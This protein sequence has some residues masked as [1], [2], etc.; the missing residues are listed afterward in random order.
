M[1]EV[2]SGRLALTHEDLDAHPARRGAEYL[3]HLLVANGVLAVRDDAL[4]RLEAWVA[5]RLAGVEDK[6]QRR[7][8]RSYATWRV[9]R[10]ARQ[11]AEAAGAP[12]TA[13]RYAK[14][15]LGSAI[16][17]LGFLAARRADLAAATQADLDDWLAE[18]PPSA[19]EVRDFLGWAADRRLAARFELPGRAAKKGPWRPTT[20]AGPQPGRCSTTRTSTWPTGWPGCSCSSTANSSAASPLLPVTGLS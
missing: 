5:G 1:R 11:Q 3:R 10:R 6:A 4:V 9:P 8:L 14:V 16:A 13:T 7:L 17:F 12:R 2:A 18:G 20:S 15:N 19:P